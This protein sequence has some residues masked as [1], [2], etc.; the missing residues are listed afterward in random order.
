MLYCL[1]Q[2]GDLNISSSVISIL[3]NISTDSIAGRAC[4]VL[5]NLAQDYCVARQLHENGAVKA[6]LSTI[7]MDSTSTT[8]EAT[9]QMAV[10]ALGYLLNKSGIA[11]MDL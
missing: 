7:P 6:L 4:R 11:F 1:F 2:A 9:R 5:G 3:H 10:R 8:S